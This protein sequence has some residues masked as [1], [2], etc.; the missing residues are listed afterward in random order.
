ML[1]I[2][3]PEPD[4]IRTFLSNQVSASFS[5]LETGATQ[6]I[7]PAGYAI[8]HTR[9][10]LGQGEATF[11]AAC[12]VLQARQ[13]LQLKWVTSWP[14]DSLVSNGENVA[15]I[16][17]ALGVWWLNACRVV[18]TIDQ[19]MLDEP[20]FGYAHGTLPDHV[21]RGEERFLV[22]MTRDDSVWFDILAFSRPN[23]LAARFGYPYLRLAQKRFGRHC[24]RRVQ[25]I[26]SNSTA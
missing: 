13:Q 21:A 11:L 8:N 23:T 3:K 20:R 25:E 7:L 17:K 2:R 24:V 26:V 19:K 12:S 14:R 5:Y 4:T 22:E 9:A 15:V 10:Q 6:R 16:G 1:L 18:Y